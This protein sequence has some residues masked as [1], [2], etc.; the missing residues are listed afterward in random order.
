MAKQISTRVL[1]LTL[2]LILIQQ[3]TIAQQQEPVIEYG[4]PADLKGIESIYIYTGSDIGLRNQIVK[5]ITK[6]LKNIVVTDRPSEGQVCLV[7][8]AAIETFYAGTTASGTVTNEGYDK[9]KV[10]AQ[11][12]P[13]YRKAT[14]GEG[15][16]VI[17]K[18][19]NVVRVIM[20]FKDSKGDGP[21]LATLFERN[22]STNF[23]RA[24]VKAYQEANKKK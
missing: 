13:Q 2:A 23:A 20:N 24:F 19:N 11:S 3:I 12:T 7:Y 16:V 9:T 17:M 14:Y 22:P 10:Q 18:P 1:L 4:S 21:P 8:G 6:K 5:E 15:S